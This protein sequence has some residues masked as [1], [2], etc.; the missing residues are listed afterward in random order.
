MVV[1]LKTIPSTALGTTSFNSLYV[2]REQL[3]HT[4]VGVNGGDGEE[5]MNDCKAC[6]MNE[7]E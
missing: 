3:K 6:C 4:N 1:T 5:D 7:G 2:I